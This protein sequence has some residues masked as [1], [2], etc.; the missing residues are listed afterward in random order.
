MDNFLKEFNDNPS[1]DVLD[2][3][4]RSAG[5]QNLHNSAMLFAKASVDFRQRNRT[6]DLL[7][8]SAA[9]FQ[10][11]SISGFYSQD[12]DDRALGRWAAE[13]L[14]IDPNVDNIYRSTARKNQ[15][16]YI[17]KLE[18]LCQIKL[19]KELKYQLPNHWFPMNP[20]IVNWQG[21]LWLI[22]RTVNYFINDTGNY[23]IKDKGNI[24]TRNYLVKLNRNFEI[25]TSNLIL[26]PENWEP[27][28]WPLVKGFEDCRLF[29]YKNELWCSATVR[30]RNIVGICEMY[31]FKIENPESSQ[32]QFKFFSVMQG[33]IANQHEKNW[34]PFTP[35]DEFKFVYS[36]DPTLVIGDRQNI[37]VNTGC[38]IAVENFRGGGQVINFEQ[39][40]LSLIHESV[41]MYNGLRQYVHRFVYFNKGMALERMSQRFKINSARIE[42]AAGL[43]QVPN[44][45]DIVFSYGINDSNSWLVVLKKDQV[46]RLLE[47]VP[48]K[49][50][51]QPKP[52][53]LT[54]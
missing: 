19:K 10:Q 48:K 33:P 46:N 8:E 21:N 49:I 28:V 7:P 18:D 12:P 14:S 20:S 39:G 36:T 13:Q 17:K 4:W 51:M 1:V 42:F 43:A 22:Q 44:S 29:V 45:T 16:F 23:Q 24:E 26:N 11:M 52:N 5:E 25:V 27:P 38:N 31:L 50:K 2:R 6:A 37:L 9:V 3:W 41:D 30:E 32:P 53:G 47:P 15:T 35:T 40:Y 34:M 54:V